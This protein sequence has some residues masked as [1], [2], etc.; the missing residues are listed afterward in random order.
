[1]KERLKYQIEAG[2]GVVYSHFEDVPQKKYRNCILIAPRACLTAKYIQCLAS[3]IRAVLHTWVVDCCKSNKLVREY[4]LP[5]GWSLE[6]KCYIGYE[7]GKERYMRLSNN[8]FNNFLIILCSDNDNFLKF[9]GRVC[10]S[11]G[12]STKVIEN[13]EADISVGSV[14]VTDFDCPLKVRKQAQSLD[15]PLV[16]TTWVVQ[17]LILGQVCNYDNIYAY[18]YMDT[19]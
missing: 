5:A 3:N 11:A 2:G 19:D 10:K 4:D 15:I 6:R 9:W 1:M 13:E 8:P 14:I 17:S 7:I 16:S 18:N 12:A